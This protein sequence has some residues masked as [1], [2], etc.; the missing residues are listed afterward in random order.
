MNNKNEYDFLRELTAADD[1]RISRVA[2]KYPALD[3]S[4]L[5]RINALCEEKLKMKE[6]NNINNHAVS[7]EEK[8]EVIR[9]IPWYRRPAFTAAACF[10][11][12]A[13]VT[14]GVMALFGGKNNDINPVESM[15]PLSN[16]ETSDAESTS[17]VTTEAAT[18]TTTTESSAVTTVEATAETN[19]AAETTEQSNESIEMADLVGKSY[20]SSKDEYKDYFQLI[21]EYSEYNDEYESGTIIEQSVNAGANIDKGSVVKV[22]VSKGSQPEN[23]DF[24]VDVPDDKTIDEL[25]NAMKLTEAFMSNG[26]ELDCDMDDNFTDESGQLYVKVTES[27]FNTIA[28]VENFMNRYFTENYIKIINSRY[29]ALTDRNSEKFI[30]KENGLYIHYAP[31]ATSFYG[32]SE[33]KA[34]VTVRKTD[35]GT[36]VVETLVNYDDFGEPSTLAL[37]LVEVSEGSWKIN[38]MEEMPIPDYNE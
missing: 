27:G 14:G 22:T 12:L 38:G 16:V 18:D 4:A 24:S 31:K 13:G 5:K 35:D 15:P 23:G 26:V 1:R 37:Q 34:I 29:K 28:D 7:E 6:N 20:E 25:I 8:V 30:E 32:I 17:D 21:V 19:I 11:V 36:E 33:Q 3:K 2:R 10:V 9:N